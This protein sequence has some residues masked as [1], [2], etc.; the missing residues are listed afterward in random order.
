MVT[1]KS[2]LVVVAAAV[3]LS[4]SVALGAGPEAAEA[5]P[6]GPKV[7]AS[8]ALKQIPAG[9]MG[10][11]VVN[12]VNGMCG[13]VDEFLKSIGPG[14]QPFLPMSVLDLIKAQLQVGEGFN[15]NGP[16]VVAMLDP[17]QYGVDLLQMMGLPGAKPAPAGEKPPE[18]P[19]VVLIPGKDPAK[20]LAAREGTKEGEYLKIGSVYWRQ[21]GSFVA[22]SPSKKALAAVAAVK[23]PVLTQLSPADNALIARNDVAV[24]VNFKIV[25]PIAQ[26][27]LKQLEKTIAES[28]PAAGPMA[29]MGPV[30]SVY[31]S[32]FKE[33]EDVA[34][35]LRFAKTGI[36]IES[37]VSFL[38]ESTMGKALAA[39]KALPGP[40]LDRLPTT[41]Y[42]LAAGFRGTSI[43]KELDLQVLDKFMAAGM[44]K[45]VSAETKAKVRK[46][47]A[48]F[49]GE[50]T[51]VQISLGAVTGGE[52]QIGL[53]Y[54]IECKSAD[55]VMGMLPDYVGVMSEI[56]KATEGE[57]VS[58]LELKY[59][60]GLEAVGDTKLDVI[61][62]DHPVLTALPE[63]D[64][65][66]LKAVLG[67][68]KIRFLVGKV[69]AKT[70]VMTLGGGKK[71][72]ATALEAAKARSGKIPAD[73]G[74]AKALAML[75]KK[76]MGVGLLN[77]G[78]IMTVVRKVAAAVDTPPPPINLI[79]PTPLAGSVSIEKSDVLMVGYIPTDAIQGIVGA[80][81]GAMMGGMMG[82]PGAGGPGGF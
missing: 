41:P 43:S 54:V 42:I 69:D 73:P 58:K 72:V 11:V 22:G 44:L 35:G 3:M 13:K 56:Y 38:A 15:S 4:G 36:L 66:K 64:R 70:V 20:M 29:G 10:F 25:G 79:A 65:A 21:V 33:L 40:L 28:G 61:S 19:A 30:L 59:H 1:R 78:N 52:G 32:L 62:I 50:V 5:K 49:E 7:P 71:F 8:A 80:V 67:D 47:A 27:A 18:V 9:C 82:G 53:V 46:M 24:W 75:P 60:K 76:R 81:M 74:A 14:G 68:D 39:T 45:G 51:G 57:I 16:L 48:E 26:A 6:L 2:F 23:K 55:K 12:N 77:L 17:Q 34:F 37:R 63:D 31:A